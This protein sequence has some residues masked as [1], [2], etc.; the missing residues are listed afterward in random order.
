MFLRSYVY[1]MVLYLILIFKVFGVVW[2]GT[3]LCIGCDMK[4]HIR[5]FWHGLTQFFLF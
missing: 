4:V 2:L 3:N 5:V 1:A